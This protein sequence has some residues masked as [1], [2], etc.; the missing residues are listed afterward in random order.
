MRKIHLAIAIL[1]LISA[2][3][4]FFGP[5]NSFSVKCDWLM[6]M[7][8]PEHS[9]NASSDCAPSSKD[10]KKTWEFKTGGGIYSSSVVKDGLMYFGNSNN[11]FYCI[12]INTGSKKWDFLIGE[13][14]KNEQKATIG[15]TAST[16]A[17]FDGK[18]YF[19]TICGSV[20]CLDEKTGK[21][22]WEYA[23]KDKEESFNS[24]IIIADEKVFCVS[25]AELVYCLDAKTGKE[26]WKTVVLNNKYSSPCF[27]DNEIY[28]ASSYFLKCLNAKSGKEQWTY[29]HRGK[30]IEH[31]EPCIYGG[32][33]FFGTVDSLLCS[34]STSGGEKS[35]ERELPKCITGIASDKSCIYF[36][37]LDKKIYCA[38]KSDGSTKWEYA[39]DTIPAASPVVGGSMVY[40]SSMS[41][42]LYVLDAETGDLVWSYKTGGPVLSAVSIYDKRVFAG[43]MDG[44]MYCFS[45]DTVATKTSL[46]KIVV[47][48]ESPNVKIKESVLFSAAGYDSEGKKIGINPKWSVDPPE[49]GTIAPSGKFTAGTKAGTCTVKACVGNICGEAQIEVIE[50]QVLTR[51][52]VRPERKEMF[53]GESMVFEAV[54]YDQ[55]GKQISNIAFVWST[56]NASVGSIDSKG[57]FLANGPGSCNVVANLGD[58]RGAA[59]VVVEDIEKIELEPDK[60]N[61]K[62]GQTYQIKVYVVTLSG[63][64]AELNKELKWSL[65]PEGQGSITKTGLFTAPNEPALKGSII[66]EY[67][68][69]TAKAEYTVEDDRRANITLST[70]LLDFGE[71]ASGQSKTLRLV[72]KN[73]GNK[74]AQIKI[75][76]DYDFIVIGQKEFLLG[77][78][79]QK[80]MA[81]IADSTKLKPGNTYNGS[82]LVTWETGE[83]SVNFMIKTAGKPKNCPK[84]SPG[85]FYFGDIKRGK[86]MSLPF[87]LDF[88]QSGAYKGTIK[89][90]AS[91]IEINPS[92][93][94]INGNRFGGTISVK[95]SA[96]PKGTDF[97]EEI[98]IQVEDCPEIKAKLKVRTENSIF[99]KLVLGEKK[100]LLN[101]DELELDVPP[102]PVGGRTLIPV[103]FISE[104][105][106]CKVDWLPSEGRITITRNDFKIVIWKDKKEALVNGK[107]FVLDVPASIIASRT[108]VPLRFISEAFGAKVEW[109]PSTKGITILWEPF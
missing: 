59:A 12:D 98:T 64:R 73:T 81:I 55:N 61:I 45:S 103:R 41:G 40:A 53:I 22:L 44:N 34:F 84:L 100:A 109:N 5:T 3:F 10:F 92:T 71:L 27:Y 51:I 107:P 82:I 86:S 20:L 6:Y 17:L 76:A 95:A 66:C 87:S 4:Q 56:N 50:P 96:M 46:E 36:G 37:G 31:S 47:T 75:T 85:E 78:G 83:A 8:G 15:G 54:A 48:S 89:A 90:S 62:K 60:I 30:T 24:A 43:S 72:L 52:E 29:W 108:L 25:T 11:M 26:I 32:K 99:V 105:F 1:F 13:S 21:K 74:D 18:V 35:W 49:M 33:V 65:D 97:E 19:G 102:Q 42:T 2:V 77:A 70:N 106:G 9:G 38:N 16:P 79:F 104:C 93:F 39:I 94:A 91:W 58:V 88:P 7:N 23:N 28:I 14:C 101:D 80:E 63:R 57:L 68:G 67:L 69:K